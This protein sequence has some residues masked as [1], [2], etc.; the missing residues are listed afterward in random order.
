MQ[1]SNS[2]FIGV[3]VVLVC[4]IVAIL[5]IY[6]FHAR[7]VSL[8]TIDRLFYHKVFVYKTNTK[9]VL[10]NSVYSHCTVKTTASIDFENVL[11][12]NLCIY[13][14]T[15][16]QIN[17]STS[18]IRELANDNIQHVESTGFELVIKREELP[19]MLELNLENPGFLRIKLE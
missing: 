12:H 5:L 9:T 11:C 4:F 16:S 6:I 2:L 15:D 19:Y 1:A 8:K 3:I 18:E 17:L 13:L 10:S 14:V 7:K